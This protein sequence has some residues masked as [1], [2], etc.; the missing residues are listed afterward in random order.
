MKVYVINACF[1][2]EP[3]QI[4]KV[5]SDKA[6]AEKRVACLNENYFFIKYGKLSPEGVNVQKLYVY[7]YGDNAIFADSYNMEEHDLSLPIVTPS[8]HAATCDSLIRRLID[9]CDESR[10]PENGVEADAQ[11]D[12][13]LSQCKVDA[14]S[15]LCM[16]NPPIT[17]AQASGASSCWADQK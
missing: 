14:A 12:K 2:C 7:D 8:Q 3:C 11:W 9:L 15:L 10:G 5:L 4:L 13:D 6:E 17:G 1:D 16:P